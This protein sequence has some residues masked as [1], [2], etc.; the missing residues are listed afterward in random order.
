MVLLPPV[1]VVALYPLLSR[2]AEELNALIRGDVLSLAAKSGEGQKYDAIFLRIAALCMIFLLGLSLSEFTFFGI[3]LSYVFA[4]VVTLLCAKRFGALSAAA[5]GFVSLFG[6]SA[7]H[8]VSLAIAGIAAGLMTGVGTVYSVLISISALAVWTGYSQGLDGFLST[9]PEYLIGSGIAFPLMKKL[10]SQSSDKSVTLSEKTAADMVGTM[11]LSYRSRYRGTLD[12]LEESLADLSSVVKKYGD[13]PEGISLD[14]YRELI[15]DS[16]EKFCKTCDAYRACLSLGRHGCVERSDELAKKLLDKHRLTDRDINTD[17]DKCILA[18]GIAAEINRGAAE[19]EAERYRKRATD[20]TA[21]DYL[22]LSKMINEARCKDDSERATDPILSEKLKEVFYSCGFTGGE[23]RVFG[24][25][26][27]HIIAAG[28]DIDGKKI[29]SAILRKR[30]EDTIG[31]KLGASEYFR[32][33]STVLMECSAARICR[34]ACAVAGVSQGDS[35]ISGDTA[36]HFESAD[37]ISYTVISDGMGSGKEAKVTSRFV[38]KFLEK[39]L[40]FSCS[41]ETAL[42]SLN[43]LL[44]SRGEECSATV[45]LFEVDLITMEAVFTKCGAAPSYVKRGSSIFRI[46]SRTAPI[47]LM[48]TIDAERI[49]VEIKPGDLV[50]MISDGVSESPDDAPWLLE[51]LAKPAPDTLADYANLILTSA[52]ANTPSRDDMTVAVTRI[53]AI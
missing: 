32:R 30:I 37:D 33:G 17:T 38:V 31:V 34:V 9:V 2:S 39:I 28:E 23:I 52:K 47:G 24:K 15:A 46:R 8:A 50:I 13:T 19:L 53:E 44:R 18:Q 1:T 48:K 36:Y 22:L 16:Q 3:S 27:K 43:H 6:V 41:G 5:V 25:R 12:L 11:A 29:T 7:T 42:H 21:E 45:D 26:R 35:E 14:E 49:K 10:H 20:F 4:S 40:N 51:L